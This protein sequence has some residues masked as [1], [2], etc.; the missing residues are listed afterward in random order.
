LNASADAIGSGATGVPESTEEK[1]DTSRIQQAIDRCAAGHAVILRSTSRDHLF[2]T[3]PLELRAGIT[4]VVDRGVVLQASRNPAVY[5][6][7]AGSCGVVNDLSA[8]CK[9]LISA[10]GVSHAGVMGE[11]VIDGRGG[12]K[13]IGKDVSWWDLA[14]Q[15]REGGRQ[16][17]PRLIVADHA[18]DFTLYEITL[19]NSPNF[20]VVYNH[21]DGIYGVGREDRYT[22]A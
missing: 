3:G 7:A 6:E 4:L 21:G 12:S 22:E 14:E 15:A 2:L 10:R 16:Q 19:K 5:E 17:V 1:L 13:L 11:G 9:P 8:G 20:H 18:D